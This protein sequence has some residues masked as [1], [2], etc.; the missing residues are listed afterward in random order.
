[1]TVYPVKKGEP[2]Q[3]SSVL[4]DLR[5]FPAGW[6]STGELWV[7]LVGARPPRLVRIE[8]PT[9]KITRSIDVDLRELGGDAM[10]DARITPDESL[11]AVEYWRYQSRLELMKGM[12]A[13]R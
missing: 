5:P 8:I 13:D 11:L 7:S 6:T 12:P 2:V 9:G 4:A 1:L 3:V 10:T